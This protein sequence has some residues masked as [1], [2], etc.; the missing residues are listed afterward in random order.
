M[1]PTARRLYR[2]VEPI[3]L[4]TY[5]CRGA[6][7]GAHGARLPELLGRLLRRAGR[8]AGPG[9]RPRWSTRSST[10]SPTARSP[11]TSR[12]SGTPTTPEAALAA[13]ERGCVA[14]LRRI[15][16][17]LAD[18]PGVARAADLATK[19]ATCSPD[20]GPALYAGA[21][22]AAHPRGTRRP[23]LARGQ[24]APRAPRRRP[25][26]R[27]GHRG[28]RRDG[29]AR[30]ARA[31]RGHARGEVRPGPPPPGGAVGRGRGRACAP[32]ASIDDVRLA[33]RRRPRRPR[34]GSRRS[35][36][37]SPLRR[38]T[39][40]SRANSTSSSPTSSPSPPSSTPPAPGSE[41][42]DARPPTR[43]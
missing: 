37:T 2:L 35:P 42:P 23:A 12:A 16:G 30:A 10:T 25:H 11:A 8:T 1:K 38:T 3:H 15:L 34:S 7:R 9:A 36:T 43:C 4:V 27:P 20:R 33:H 19:A 26:R 5:F 13:R 17:D 32:A 18:G 6:D 29:G 28:H 39:S 40:S 24:P 14:A 22:G 21:A 31:V 41:L